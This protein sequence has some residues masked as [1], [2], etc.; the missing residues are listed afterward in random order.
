M[1]I[2]A[3]I[4]EAGRGPVLGPLIMVG[5]AMEEQ[6]AEK[7]KAM[8]V[9]DS[10]QLTIKQICK[11]KE[12]ILKIPNK[13]LILKIQP[14]EIDNA[15]DGNNGLN[16]NWLEARKTSEMLNQ[17]NPDKA[18]IDCPSPNIQKYKNYLKRFLKNKDMELVVEHKAD[19][20]FPITSASSIIAKCIREEEVAKIE[21]RVGQSIGSGYPSN[22]ICQKFLRENHEKYP[23]LIRHSWESYKRIIHNQHQKKLGEY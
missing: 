3:G 19:V 16:L 17:L 1:A 13:H 11:L 21:Q 14:A 4:E 15:V 8:G 22:P 18:F 10:K 7:L 20:K 9:K 5:L 23:E 6:D 2:I 12:R